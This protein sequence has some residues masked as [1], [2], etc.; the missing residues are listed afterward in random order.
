METEAAAEEEE[1]G[2]EITGRR[3]RLRPARRPFPSRRTSASKS[4][5]ASTGK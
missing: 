4:P 2:E 5:S 1:L 3:D